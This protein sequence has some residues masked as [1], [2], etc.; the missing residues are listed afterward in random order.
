MVSGA[1]A[2]AGWAGAGYG[3]FLT[4]T[5]L[6]SLPGAGLT[7]HWVAQPAF[8]ASMAVLLA[9][10]AAAH[11]ILREARWLIP[12]LAL[13]ATGDWLLAIPWWESSFTAGLT[14]FLLA[15]L[16]FLGALLPLA[17]RSPGRLVGV[18]VICLAGVALLVWF[19][20]GLTR[21]GLAVQVT[22]YV[23][24]LAAMVCAALLAGLP[25]RWT[26]V[27]AVCFAVSDAMIGI[28]RF[29][30]G[31]EVLAVPIWWTYAVAQLLITA[32]FFFGRSSAGARKPG[33]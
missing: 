7:G 21:D 6:R 30:L 16:C 33:E 25:T 18:A 32:G 31:N 20:P 5:A 28:D 22:G 29:V 9:V 4:V 13:S 3:L 10:A 17:V 12:A 14:A 15:H 1:W 23:G 26:A 11:P 24:V 8:K 27:G 19:W 2:V